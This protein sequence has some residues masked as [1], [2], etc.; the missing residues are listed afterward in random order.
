VE[1]I[2]REILGRSLAEKPGTVPAGKIALQFH[3][4]EVKFDRCMMIELAF[5][6][7]WPSKCG[8]MNS[9]DPCR[10]IGYRGTQLRKF[11]HLSPCCLPVGYTYW[12]LRYRHINENM[13]GYKE[14]S[15]TNIGTMACLRPGRQK[16]EVNKAEVEALT[17]IVRESRS[18]T[19]DG[20]D[21]S[22]TKLAPHSIKYHSCPV[23]RRQQSN[24]SQLT[25]ELEVAAV[26]PNREITFVSM[27]VLS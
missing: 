18:V 21:A 1:T 5:I 10:M 20:Y 11:Y 24:V 23:D 15:R 12:R 2:R 7:L 9:D 8:A 17:N 6:R 3:E 13:I 16:Y 14:G 22:H 27:D 19:V 4:S 25:V 26:K